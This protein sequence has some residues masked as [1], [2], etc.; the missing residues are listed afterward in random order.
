MINR[1]QVLQLSASLLAYPSLDLHAAPA[2]SSTSA[3]T[4]TLPLIQR[5]IPSSGELLPV[6]GMGTSRTFDTAGDPESLAKLT[7]VMQA[8][9][10]RW[11]QGHR[12]LP[13]VRQRRN[14]RR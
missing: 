13:D 10:W 8:L 9:L 5:P 11:R 1:R 3:L 4:S 12:L 2:A 7:E 6:M 14:P